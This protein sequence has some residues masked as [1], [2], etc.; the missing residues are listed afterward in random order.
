MKRIPVWFGEVWG[1]WRAFHRAE[2][3]KER[4]RL[5]EELFNHRRLKPYLLRRIGWQ[6]QKLQSPVCDEWEM[7]GDIYNEVFTTLW[8]LGVGPR[9]ERSAGDGGNGVGAENVG[10]FYDFLCKRVDRASWRVVGK[11]LRERRSRPIPVSN[12]LLDSLEAGVPLRLHEVQL[13]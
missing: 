9:V 2:S 11:E 7:R 8:R 1:V 12:D 6:T 3:G 5:F 4:E 10:Q 13:V